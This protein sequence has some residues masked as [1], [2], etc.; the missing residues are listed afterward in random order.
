MMQ[1][2]SQ[3]DLITVNTSVIYVE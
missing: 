3:P 2:Y 1:N